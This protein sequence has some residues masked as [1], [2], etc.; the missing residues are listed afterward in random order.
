MR[1]LIRRKVVILMY[2]GFTDEEIHKGIENYQQKHLVAGTFR[3]QIEYLKRYYNVISLDQLVDCYRDGKEFPDNSVVITIDDGYQS[4]Y[5]IAYPILKQYGIPATI[6]LTGNFIENKEFLRMDRIEYAISETKATELKI[7]I[8]DDLLAFNL[9]SRELKMLCDREIRARLKAL[10]PQEL[11]DEVIED[12]ETSLGQRLSENREPHQIYRPLTWNE[13]EEM[14]DDRGIMSIGSHA[15]NHVILSRCSREDAR[16]E[17]CKSK[18]LI[19]RQTGSSCRLFS[20]PNGA[21]GD[22][23]H[24]TKELLKDIGYMC[25]LVGVR[26]MNDRHSDVFE[27]KRLSL[28]R[29]EDLSGFAMLLSGIG[30]IAEAWRSMISVFRRNYGSKISKGIARPLIFTNCHGPQERTKYN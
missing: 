10:Q 21:V 9:G 11:M 3:M 14:V 13:V 12:L 8:G 17:L 15:M 28:H 6:F 19:E 25:G 1:L 26:G 5:S 7:R 27:L 2:H 16:E 30:F 22:F 24:H 4:N 20:Y 18:E 23:D 29:D